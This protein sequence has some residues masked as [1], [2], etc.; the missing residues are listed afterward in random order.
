M[1]FGTLIISNILPEILQNIG[2]I[3]Q[4]LGHVQ[5]SNKL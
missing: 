1:K 4:N 5:L 2:H 3:G